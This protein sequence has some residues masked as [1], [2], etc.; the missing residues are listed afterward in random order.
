MPQTATTGNLADAQRIIIAAVRY[1]EEHNTP[2]MQL[3][4]HMTLEKGAKQ[5]TVPK[6]G[7]MSMADLVDGQDIVDE[8]EIGMTTVDLTSAEVGAKIIISDVLVRQSQPSV[9]TMVGRQLGEGM[10][11]KQDNDVT[12]LYAGLNGG[13]V[14]GGSNKF[15]TAINF[16]AAIAVA[17]GKTTNPYRPT[18]CN[19]HPHSVY[20]YIKTVTGI[21]STVEWPDEFS[22]DKLKNFY[23]Q[24]SFNGVALFEDGNITLAGTLGDATI[25]VLASKDALV[26]LRSMA[27]KT[28]RQRD[29]SLRATE[30]VMTADYGVFELDDEKG[31][32]MTYD[33]SALQTAG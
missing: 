4:E 19:M 30:L 20:D 7:Q 27:T 29:A 5:V 2:A 23:S 6:V 13:T 1:T 24:R 21:A 32:P 14:L 33:A 17:R 31:H 11:R 26:V 22:R 12:A 15:L 9:F 16:S 28:E 18:Y 25:G 10:A 3:I 8:E